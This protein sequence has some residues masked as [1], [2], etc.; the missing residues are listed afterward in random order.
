[1]SDTTFAALIIIVFAI[2]CC[3]L[4]LWVIVGERTPRTPR[5]DPLA[6]LSADA[7]KVIDDA[8]KVID[9]REDR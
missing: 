9:T 6:G 8:R 4:A 3:A 2:T 5:P 1:M 7:R